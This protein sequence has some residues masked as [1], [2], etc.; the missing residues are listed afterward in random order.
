MAERQ[1]SIG[2]LW[3]KTSRGGQNFMSGVIEVDGT[4]HEIV[5][6]P[7][8]KGDNPKRPD[9]RIFPSVRREE[10]DEGTPF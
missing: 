10:A 8:D 9:F 7:N 1:Q 6:F 3:S 2:A 4:K 5:I